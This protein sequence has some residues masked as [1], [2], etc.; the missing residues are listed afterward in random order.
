MAQ[1]HAYTIKALAEHWSCSTDTIRALLAQGEIK[2]FR[3]GTTYRIPAS[4]VERY[5]NTH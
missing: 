5:E 1:E 4:E 2:A 3:L